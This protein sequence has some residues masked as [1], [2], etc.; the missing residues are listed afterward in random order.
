MKYSNF[1]EDVIPLS[2]IREFNN[3]N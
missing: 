2:P 1:E 3:E